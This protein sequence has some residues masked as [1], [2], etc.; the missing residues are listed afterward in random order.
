[1]KTGNI[2]SFSKSNR[3][4]AV[5]LLVSLAGITGTILF[6][7]VQLDGRYTCYYHRIFDE[8]HP[9]RNHESDV[10]ERNMMHRQKGV[11]EP[12]LHE[13]SDIFLEKYIKSY[14]GLWW[15][16]IALIVLSYYGWKK[17]QINKQDIKW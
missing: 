17:L 11:S 2:L 16:S 10:S 3:W 13:H 7:P 15:G 4:R 8:H 12:D 9:V 6:F 5:F 1:M 14:V